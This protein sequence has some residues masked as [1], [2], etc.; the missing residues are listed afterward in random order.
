MRDCSIELD[1]RVV[2]KDGRIVDEAMRVA[3]VKR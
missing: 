3:R 1:G 2:V